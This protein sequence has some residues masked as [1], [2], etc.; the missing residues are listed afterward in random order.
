MVLCIMFIFLFHCTDYTLYEIASR[1]LRVSHGRFLSCIGLLGGVSFAVLS[2]SQRLCGLYP[3]AAEVIKYGAMSPELLAQ[4][5]GNLP[6]TYNLIGRKSK[7][8]IE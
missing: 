5:P 7:D 8:Q 3:N 4:H 6:D 1:S 2:S